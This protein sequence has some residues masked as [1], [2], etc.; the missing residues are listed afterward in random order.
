MLLAPQ[1]CIIGSLLTSLLTNI[2]A[3]NMINVIKY[4]LLN[5]KD[6]FLLQGLSNLVLSL[7]HSQE[8]S[9]GSDA[10]MTG[11]S[12]GLGTSQDDTVS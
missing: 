1:I 2:S 4:C 11:V 9:G 8:V 5:N 10:E 7:T 3:I 6:L 12:P